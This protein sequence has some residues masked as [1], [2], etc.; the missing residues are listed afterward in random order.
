MLKPALALLMMGIPM[1]IPAGDCFTH[2]IIIHELVI[3]SCEVL[4][5]SNAASISQVATP[6]TIA[7][8]Y[9]GAILSAKEE[10]KRT[11]EIDD[12]S[13]RNPTPRAWQKVDKPIQFLF[14]SNDPEICSHFPKG[15][16]TMVA[17]HTNCE[18]DTG[19]HPDGYC[20]LTVNQV[21][22]IPKKFDQY[23]R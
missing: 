23:A 17:Y 15:K 5:E 2:P 19:A 14:V 10:R 18:C 21:S 12:P 1:S 7:S 11:I 3:N 20:A 22:E 16:K 13:R 6:A 8:R 9:H 4:S